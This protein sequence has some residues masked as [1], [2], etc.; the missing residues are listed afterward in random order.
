MRYYARVFFHE[1]QW[2]RETHILILFFVVVMALL[3]SRRT[4]F[5]ATKQGGGELP[6]DIGYPGK[7]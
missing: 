1:M 2:S 3:V 4:A 5:W 7:R 6:Q